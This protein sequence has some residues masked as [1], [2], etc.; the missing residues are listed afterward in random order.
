MRIGP[1]HR[2]GSD[3]NDATKPMRRQG[4]GELLLL[5]GAGLFASESFGGGS[6]I[7]GGL[8]FLLVLVG[9]GLILD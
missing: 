1:L 6:A 7:G 2:P 8:G 3:E 5:V 4:V 9:A